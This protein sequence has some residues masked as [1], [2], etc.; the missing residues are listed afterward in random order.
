MR[1]VR[2]VALLV[3]AS[4]LVAVV[5]GSGAS[6]QAPATRTLSY[7]ELEKGSTFVH[8]RNTRARSPRANKM[9]DQIVFT[10]PLADASGTIVGTSHVD[11][12]TTRGARNF[13]RS[14]LVC[15]GVA[16]LRDGTVTLQATVSP[17]IRTTTGAVTGGTGA[18]A[19]A[20]GVFVSEE[21]RG[22]A[23]TTVTL[24]G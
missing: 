9:G 23:Q 5:A 1:I 12:T 6:A 7:T 16:V 11:C 17:G 13:M 22:G 21:Q 8:I 10:N 18:Y 3:A 15:N 2:P 24:V 19:N 20:R 14:I 4:G